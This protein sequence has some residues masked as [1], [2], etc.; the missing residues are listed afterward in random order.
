MAQSKRVSSDINISMCRIK[1]QVAGN[2]LVATGS[3][4][5]LRWPWEIEFASS[6]A[7]GKNRAFVITTSQVFS[8]RDSNSKTAWIADFLPL[9]WS[10]GKEKFSLNGVAV[11]EVLIPSQNHAITLTFIPTETLH[12]QKIMSRWRTDRLNASRSQLCHQKDKTYNEEELQAADR[13]QLLC[14]VISETAMEEDKFILHCYR[15]CEDGSESYF[16]QDHGN[17]A[18]IRTLKDFQSSEKP[19][20]S[21]ILN[22]SGDA[23]GL[24]AFGDKDEVLPL[25]F[26]QNMPGKFH[27]IKYLVSCIPGAC[28]IHAGI[29]LHLRLGHLGKKCCCIF[30]LYL[31]VRTCETHE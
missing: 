14:F 25:F 1:K 4:C 8:Q 16:L 19:K 27:R 10:I 12:N 22:E 3:A 24:L 9:K 17:K 23:V 2:H 31:G 29:I 5:V 11:Y 28:I 7:Q 20:G 21:I 6:E 18:E 30:G 15:L 26:A 13:K